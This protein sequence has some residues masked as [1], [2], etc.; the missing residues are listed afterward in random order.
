MWHE[1]CLRLDWPW[2]WALEPGL[3]G[4]QEPTRVVGA[5]ACVW[6][7]AVRMDGVAAPLPPRP[8]R[9]AEP[10][11]PPGLCKV[12]GDGQEP[13]GLWPEPPRLARGREGC[14]RTPCTTVATSSTSGT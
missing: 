1:R 6:G 10:S 8:R 2:H 5:A 4:G 14:I 11:P 3:H 9:L 7:A 12:A 13:T